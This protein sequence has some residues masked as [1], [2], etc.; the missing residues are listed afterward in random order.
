VEKE[1]NGFF[2]RN[3]Q[4]RM[5]PETTNDHSA[6]HPTDENGT[7]VLGLGNSMLQ[8]KATTSRSF[9]MD[10]DDDYGAVEYFR[11]YVKRLFPKIVY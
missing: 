5:Q 11:V 2:Q 10:R 7:P 3:R 9:Q 6:E 8:P 1:N 4:V